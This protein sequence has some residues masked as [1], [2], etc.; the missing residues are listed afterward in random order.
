M[1][2]K[3]KNERTSLPHHQSASDPS[4]DI[5]VHSRHVLFSGTE[6]RRVKVNVC[7]ILVQFS[8]TFLEGTFKSSCVENWISNIERRIDSS[9]SVSQAICVSILS[10]CSDFYRCA[11]CDHAWIVWMGCLEVCNQRCNMVVHHSASA[12][13]VYH[14]HS[15]RFANRHVCR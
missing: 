6:M 1:K 2:K 10:R 13:P 7:C 5:N 9:N 3:K 14:C 15:S 8:L 4:F 12:R 11:V